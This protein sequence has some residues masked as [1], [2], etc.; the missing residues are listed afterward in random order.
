MITPLSFFR[1][2]KHWLPVLLWMGLI[3]ALSTRLGTA[4]NTSRF[5]EPLLRWLVPDI[6]RATMD[7]IH[8][9]VR[10][11]AHMTEYAILALLT[12]R[13]VRISWR[14]R[15]RNGFYATAGIALAIAAAYAATDEFHQCFVPGRTPSL[16]DVL[17]DSGGAAAG[18]AVAALIRRFQLVRRPSE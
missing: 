4:A 6:D 17:I 5:I 10:K 14:D 11:G 18:L 8:G 13:A 1:A 7:V 3:F 9:L 2:Q 15:P 16:G 12:L